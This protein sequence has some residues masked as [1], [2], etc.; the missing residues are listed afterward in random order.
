[1]ARYAAAY[2]MDA[3]DWYLNLALRGA[4]ARGE[5]KQFGL[6][7][8]RGPRPVIRRAAELPP[9][10]ASIASELGGD[11]ADMLDGKAPRSGVEHLSAE[12]FYFFE[13]SYQRRFED[14]ALSMCPL[15]RA[16]RGAAGF[17][18]PVDHL[19]SRDF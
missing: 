2:E 5:C 11:F 4:I 3:A 16:K 19:S 18:E 6:A 8:V 1:M 12:E 10:F 14:M 13:A 17:S 15:N 7:Y 9:Q